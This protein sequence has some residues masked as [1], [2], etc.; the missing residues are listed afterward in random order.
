MNLL[1][2][3]ITYIRRIIKSPSDALI[4]DDLIIDY[5]N[6]FWIMDVD[7]RIQLFDLK[8]KYQFMT[9]PG[10]DQYNMPLYSIQSETPGIPSSQ[11]IGMFPVYQGFLAPAYINGVRV[12][13]ETQK[14]S[15]FNAWPNVVQNNAIV[16]VGDGSS[17]PYT[18][19]FPILPNFPIPPNPPLQGI[20]RGH[21]DITGVTSFLRP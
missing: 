20:L 14:T 5:I 2:D 18:L 8:T 16:G 11:D 3:I 1:S 4:S 6:R 12:V 15:F 13:L 21:V 7:A 10:V 9:S 19:N 17:G